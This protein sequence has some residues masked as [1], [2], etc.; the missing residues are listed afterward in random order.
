MNALNWGNPFYGAQLE[1]NAAVDASLSEVAEEI[2]LVAVLRIELM[3]VTQVGA[4]LLGCNGRVVPTGPHCAITVA[5]RHGRSSGF[6]DFPQPLLLIAIIEDADIRQAVRITKLRDEDVSM[7]TRFVRRVAAEL[8]VQPPASG[9][10]ESQVVGMQSAVRARANQ[11]LVHP[12]ESDRM[13]LED[14]G[15]R[16]GCIEDVAITEDDEH[17][18]REVAH[19]VEAC[20]EHKHER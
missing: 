16:L 9:R 12:F 19:Q 18:L 5:G 1:I 6:A 2:R 10:Q 8:D 14:R 15:H 3:E 11:H 7:L 13:M 20:F 17:A 4:E